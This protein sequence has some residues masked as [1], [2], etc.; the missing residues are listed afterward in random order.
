MTVVRVLRNAASLTNSTEGFAVSYCLVLPVNVCVCVCLI[1]TARLI[2]V[3]SARLATNWESN[4]WLFV[5]V[6]SAESSHPLNV[7]LYISFLFTSASGNLH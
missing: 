3:S 6:L 1:S 2:H 7:P 5:S 4:F